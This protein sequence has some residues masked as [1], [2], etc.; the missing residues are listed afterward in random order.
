MDA[1]TRQRLLELVYD[2]LPEDEAAQ[3]RGRIDA[4]A[5]IAAAYRHAQETARLL[6][7]AARLPSGGIPAIQFA[8][9]IEQG[10]PASLPAAPAPQLVAKNAAA[11]RSFARA[12]NWTVGLAAAVL[13]LISVGGYVYHRQKLAAIAVKHLRLV[14]TGPSTIQAGVPTEYLVSTSDINNE[15]LPAKVE[16]T[17]SGDDGQRLKAFKETVDEHGRLRIAIPTDLRLPP[18]TLFR[19]VAWHG[20]S[21]DETEATLPVE[22]AGYD[23][24]IALD[25]PLYQP[26]DVVRYRALVLSHFGLTADRDVPVQ[27]EILDPAGAVLA[28]SPLRAKSTHGVADGA[29]AIPAQSA[30]GQYTLVAHAGDGSFLTQKRKFFVRRYRLPKLKK[31]LEFA[32][33]SY[34]PGQTVAADFK[35]Q[36][37][38]GGA[39]GGAKV[40]L[41]ATVD[42][43]TVLERNTQTTDAGTLHV[44]FPLPKNIEHGDGQLAVI[45]DDGG[46]RETEAKTIPINLGK[47]DVTF[48]P[49][50]GELAAGLEN[51]VYF[52]ARNPQ[53]K[54]VDLTGTLVA[55]QSGDR[56]TVDQSIP[57]QTAYEGMGSF[58]FTPTAGTK[59]RLKITQPLG[60]SNEPKLPAVSAES[61]VVLSTGPGVFSAGK[62]IELS[63]RSA[64]AGLPLVVAA[65]CRG[66]QVGQQPIVTKGVGE[67]ANPV[68]IAL[69]DA[70]GGVIRLTVYDY[71]LSPP[72]PV[73]ERLVYRRPAGKLN[74]RAAGHAERYT[75]GEKV[76]MSLLV[77]DENEKPVPAVLGVAVA[78]DALLNLADDRTPAMPTHFLLTSEIEKPEDLEHAD[79]FLSD[80]TK[81]TTTAAEALD[82]LLG[83]QGW[84]RFVE[85]SL[86]A[87]NGQGTV[88]IFAPRG[89]S[90]FSRQRKWDCPPRT[91]KNPTPRNSPNSPSS[92]PASRR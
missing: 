91:A 46:S 60:V 12:A 19:V 81:G 18:R 2:L 28:G 73:A 86:V 29:F 56:G 79:F 6:A 30:G 84:R 15:P 49:E 64:K 72:K 82:L 66:V 89:L 87:A 85:K 36:R 32:R 69:D 44:E 31:E 24:Q 13:V 75:P 23:A 47:I 58:S 70:V 33:D 65:Y 88:P 57:V 20:E 38:E 22:S 48:Y 3:L 74:I 21:H 27:F 14:V 41:L 71:G 16:V 68:A 61:D 43:Q 26:G 92:A 10:K 39:A 53:G 34:G 83:T 80:Q 40:R 78:D 7:E 11:G 51:R 35:A 37:A 4:D 55:E 25:R 5:E 9:A 62:P 67:E 76:D 77:T 17:L 50:G 1:E 59:Y 42:G 90:R 63:I 8:K 54:P 45:I 52:V